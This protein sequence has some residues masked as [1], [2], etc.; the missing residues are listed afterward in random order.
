MKNETKIFIAIAAIVILF[1][2]GL[3]TGL[4]IRKAIDNR[5]VREY[6]STIDDIRSKLVGQAE[7]NRELEAANTELAEQLDR[8]RRDLEKTKSIIDE[9]RAGLSGDI[10][11]IQQIRK[12]IRSVIEAVNKLGETE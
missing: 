2:G 1:V 4:A 7:T 6:R 10:S 11:T 3:C 8:Y 5:A 12:A 9:I